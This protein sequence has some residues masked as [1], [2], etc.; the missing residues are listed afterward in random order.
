MGQAL[1]TVQ[2]YSHGRKHSTV[3]GYHLH[4]AKYLT[5][6]QPEAHLPISSPLNDKVDLAGKTTIITGGN[7][8]IG[9]SVATYAAS[10]NAEV[11]L[12]CRSKERG[13][14]AAAAITTLTLNENVRCIQCDVGDK[15]SIDAAVS[16]LKGK[17]ID[18]LVCNAGVLLNDRQ[19]TADGIEQ[20]VATHLI[21]GSYYLT[22]KVLPS[23]TDSGKV[24]FVSSGGMYN[25]KF[26]SWDGAMSTDIS[27]YS[28]N[29]AYAYAKRGQ[30]LLAQVFQNT[31]KAKPGQRFVSCHPGWVDTPAV[32]L[33]YGKG[34]KWLEPMRNGW[35]GAEGIAW[36]V[37]AKSEEV[38]GGE[39]YL[40]RQVQEKHL[41]SRTVN[42]DEEIG[43]M[44][45]KLK[46]VTG[47]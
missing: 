18:S 5:P 32:D 10:K 42:S 28:G 31:I 1:T 2:F 3:T 14:A 29:S 4:V 13:D 27:R 9:L 37:G 12:F 47:V 7:S 38:V 41:T 34:K 16:S 21:M 45:A 40:D 30:V 43:N 36:L 24:I 35:Q 8:G 22:K 26:P 39:F 44:M 20:T 33:A 11:L 25:F 19:V 46:E 6:P 17:Q 23:L 15:K